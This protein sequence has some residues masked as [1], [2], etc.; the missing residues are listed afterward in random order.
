MFA[1]N[2]YIHLAK[3]PFCHPSDETV[4]LLSRGGVTHDDPI[5]MFQYG[6]TLVPLVEELRDVGPTLLSPF[7]ANDAEFDG[8]AQ[9]S[10]E[11][12]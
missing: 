9:L 8:L 5:S 4:I 6:I 1:F 3:L 12:L 7:Y 11:K 2:C 10:A